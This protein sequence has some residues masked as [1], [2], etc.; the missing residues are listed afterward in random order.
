MSLVTPTCNSERI[1]CVTRHNMTTDQVGWSRRCGAQVGAAS[2]TQI[3]LQQSSQRTA[4]YGLVSWHLSCDFFDR[5]LMKFCF[6]NRVQVGQQ[7]KH[8]QISLEKVLPL[9]D[10]AL[11]IKC[12]L[13]FSWIPRLCLRLHG[14]ELV[15]A[16]K[17]YNLG[18]FIIIN[19]H[20]KSLWL[21]C[22]EVWLV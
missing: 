16:T 6:L 1:C 15:R 8:K 14:S 9:P 2:Q 5:S 21:N 3:L 20:W 10:F 18:C 12:V 22:R 11:S 7:A 19:T 17:M 4:A 13:W